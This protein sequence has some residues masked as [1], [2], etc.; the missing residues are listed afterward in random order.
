M[1]NKYF[2]GLTIVPTIILISAIAEAE[3]IEIRTRNIDVYR[4][5]NG[6]IYLDTGRVRVNSSSPRFPYRRR[7]ELRPN[8]LRCDRL[9]MLRQSSRQYYSFGRSSQQRIISEIC[10]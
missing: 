1:K 7:L 8:R 4:E 2:I 5:Q 6:N 3:D 10:Y 9:G